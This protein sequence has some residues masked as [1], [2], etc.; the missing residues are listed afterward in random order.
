LELA[1]LHMG[2]L[3]EAPPVASMP[4]LGHLTHALGSINFSY[5]S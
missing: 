1:E 2:N 5:E 3:H 4:P